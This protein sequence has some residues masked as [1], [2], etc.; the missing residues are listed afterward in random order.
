[1]CWRQTAAGCSGKPGRLRAARALLHV[2]SG[3]STSAQRLRLKTFRC[4]PP[5]TT[6]VLTC[7]A[8]EPSTNI[9]P[10]ILIPRQAPARLSSLLLDNSLHR[11][12]R[13]KTKLLVL[14]LPPCSRCRPDGK[15]SRILPPAKHTTRTISQNRR[16][17]KSLPRK[18]EAET[19]NH[20]AKRGVA[21]SC[22]T[23]VF[24]ATCHATCR[25]RHR[26]S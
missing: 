18:G 4:R 21:V 8:V 20:G 25:L 1:M 10:R 9:K 11:N 19:C 3:T 15:R 26:R 16:S 22:C 7:V 13:S 23:R 6:G 5:T 24:H 2:I 12:H 17:G 14:V